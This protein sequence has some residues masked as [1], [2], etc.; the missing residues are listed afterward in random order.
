MNLLSPSVTWRSW[1]EKWGNWSV[2]RGTLNHRAV[3]P[4]VV[5]NQ[6]VGRAQASTDMLARQTS[7]GPT[8]EGLR[9]RQ[10]IL[11]NVSVRD[12]RAGAGSL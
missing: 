8:I 11:D 3:W 2:W 4:V 6:V 9:P 10:T 7:I 5:G 1:S 12:Q